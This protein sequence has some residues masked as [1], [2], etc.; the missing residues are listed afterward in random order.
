MKT[1]NWAAFAVV[2]TLATVAVAASRGGGQSD[3]RGVVYI[4]EYFERRPPTIRFV[5]YHERLNDEG[6][7]VFEHG[8]GWADAA[9]AIWWARRRAPLVI[10][11][12]GDD[13]A[14]SR[15]WSAGATKRDTLDGRPLADWP[16]PYMPDGVRVDN[17]GGVVFVAEV[18]MTLTATHLEG[19]WQDR[20]DAADAEPSVIETARF[21]TIESAVRWANARSDYVI[22]QLDPPPHTQYSAGAVDPPHVNLPRLD[23]AILPPVLHGPPIRD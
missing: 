19:R 11:R 15:E 5:G 10:V 20:F 21:P 2:A 17:Y 12:T 6:E 18:P 7:A 14:R 8:P 9:E 4:E 3:R 16:G 23:D 1:R 13:A 22:V